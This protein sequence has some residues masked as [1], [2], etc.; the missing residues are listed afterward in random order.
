[1]TE[2]EIVQYI[3][4]HI[5]EYGSAGLNITWLNKPQ[6]PTL[7]PML[8]DMPALGLRFVLTPEKYSVGE[9]VHP[10]GEEI[11]VS[12]MA[13]ILDL[14]KVR[15]NE[16]GFGKRN[17]IATLLGVD[18]T[19]YSHIENGQYQLSLKLFLRICRML[20]I[21]VRVEQTDNPYSGELF[22]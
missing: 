9:V 20:H 12:T 4:H 11:P 19:Y 7:E 6:L 13:D 18:P 8:R 14:L 10:E 16:L 22:G 15:R 3:E 21:D 5:N 17:D 1:M 2:Y